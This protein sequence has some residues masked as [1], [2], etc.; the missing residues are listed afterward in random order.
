MFDTLV[1]KNVKKKKCSKGKYAFIDNMSTG[2]KRRLMNVWED[3]INAAKFGLD[4]GSAT[5]D[6]CL[7]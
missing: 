4:Q 1:I 7:F 5:C 6:K 3:N 2:P